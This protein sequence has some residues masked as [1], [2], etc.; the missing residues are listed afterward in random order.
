MVP[1]QVNSQTVVL[2]SVTVHV[3]NYVRED[4]DNTAVIVV[5]K[6][7]W[8]KLPPFKDGTPMLLNL[9]SES[10]HYKLV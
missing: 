1:S 6:L 8:L 10:S 3:V 7:V 9:A 5:C 4:Y 2:Q